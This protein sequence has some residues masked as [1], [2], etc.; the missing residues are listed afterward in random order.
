MAHALQA[1]LQGEEREVP[2]GRPAEEKQKRPVISTF[3]ICILLLALGVGGYYVHKMVPGE[4]DVK[5]TPATPFSPPVAEV[6]SASLK[7]DSVPMG[8]QVFL[9]GLLKGKTP[10]NIEVPFGRYEVRLSLPQYHDWEA[11]LH[12]SQAG[13]TPLHISLVPIHQ[14][15]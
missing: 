4:P 7:V 3:I 8:A 1:C 5:H 14:K 9:D 11:Q 15:F 6:E 12:L 2:T 13:E 10:L